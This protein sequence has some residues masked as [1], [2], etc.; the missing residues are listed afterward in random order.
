VSV[1]VERLRRAVFI[2][3]DPQPDGSAVVHGH[4][5]TLDGCDCRD[6]A[7]RGGPCKHLLAWKLA[8]L[9]PDVFAGLRE[10][11]WPPPTREPGT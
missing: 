5:V 2:D 8:A 9:E 1:D 6:H 11:V 7:I 4:R 10:L 3:V